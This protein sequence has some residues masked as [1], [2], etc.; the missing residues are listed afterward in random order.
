MR[1][2]RTA[3]GAV[4]RPAGNFERERTVKRFRKKRGI[5]LEYVV[6]L[7]SIL[8]LI[9]AVSASVYSM[10]SFTGG[11]GAL[12]RSVV[13]LYQRIVTVVSLPIP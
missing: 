2:I 1:S 9:F 11:F 7:C 4:R 3:R 10:G 6:L 5:L 8:P 13:H 12:G